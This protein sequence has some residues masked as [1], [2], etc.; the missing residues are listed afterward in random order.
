MWA[1]LHNLEA[2][3][4]HEDII[5][6]DGGDKTV[7]DTPKQAM[8]L[9]FDVDDSYICIGRHW[10]FLVQGNGEDIVSDYTVDPKIEAAVDAAMQHVGLN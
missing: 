10:V 6:D 2:A 9:I 5:V 3:L 1:L 7:C 8:E 4:P